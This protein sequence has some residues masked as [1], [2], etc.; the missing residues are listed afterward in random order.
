MTFDKLLKELR[1]NRGYSQA[2]LAWAAC[3]N[4][5]DVSNYEAGK[6]L[7]SKSAMQ[8]I[9]DALGITRA[10]IERACAESRLVAREVQNEEANHSES[11]P[12]QE[13]PEHPPG[14]GEQGGH[15]NG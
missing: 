15:G 9:A 5:S 1:T 12:G 7:P 3:V 10:E 11:R 6:T 4:Q 2:E 14:E 13:G 8:T